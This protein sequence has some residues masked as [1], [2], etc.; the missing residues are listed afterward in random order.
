MQSSRDI[1]PRERGNSFMYKS[2]QPGVEVIPETNYLPAHLVD[3][4]YSRLFLKIHNLGRDDKLRV[5][6]FLCNELNLEAN[7]Y[8]SE[9][10]AG[11]SGKLIK[12]ILLLFFCLSV[13]FLGTILLR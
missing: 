7:H 9:Y 3:V 12:R 10:T 11:N 5:F 4:G 6:Y 8:I 2:T 1:A 13:M